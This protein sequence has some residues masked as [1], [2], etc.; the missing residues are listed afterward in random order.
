MV[1]GVQTCALPIYGIHL[2]GDNDFTEVLSHCFSGFEI[3]LLSIIPENDLLDYPEQSANPSLPEL[4]SGELIL[5]ASLEH[6]A[7]LAELL[8]QQGLQKNKH[9]VLFL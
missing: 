9:W 5:L 2:C 8:A 7:A 6:P 1:T 3:E 4:K